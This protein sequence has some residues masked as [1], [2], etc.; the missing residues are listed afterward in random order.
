VQPAPVA[1]P[2]TDEQETYAEQVLHASV[3]IVGDVHDH[4]PQAVQQSID[5]ALIIPSPE[6]VDPVHALVTVLAAQVPMESPGSERLGWIRDSEHVRER[7]GCTPA[8]DITL[9]ELDEELAAAFNPD[10]IADVL[11][12]VLGETEL[13][14]LPVATRVFAAGY[15]HRLGRSKREIARLLRCD[16][17]TI[18]RYLARAA[19]DEAA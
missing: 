1:A 5:A 9:D 12:V 18:N 15:L 14:L 13:L 6:G 8:R 4:G 11:N 16:D 2:I 19:G 10:P 17:S 3:L 7:V